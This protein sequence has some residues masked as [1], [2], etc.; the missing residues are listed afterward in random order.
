[1]SRVQYFP[2]P[3]SLWEG[4]STTT[5]TV[6]ERNAQMTMINSIDAMPCP[7][8]IP[9]D[10]VLGNMKMS[11]QTNFKNG[12]NEQH[13]S[14]MLL[15]DDEL[16][17]SEKLKQHIFTQ[18]SLRTAWPSKCSPPTSLSVMNSEETAI[19][20]E[21]LCG[22]K[23]WGEGKGYAAMFKSNGICGYMLPCLSIVALKEELGIEMFGHRLEIVAAIEQNELTLMN[24]I[25]VSLNPNMSFRLG[26]SQVNSSDLNQNK[27]KKHRK[28]HKKD[29]N[30]YKK[31]EQFSNCASKTTEIPSDTMRIAEG[32]GRRLE[33]NGARHKSGSVRMFNNSVI[34]MRGGGVFRVER[35]VEAPK[36]PWIPFL[37]LPPC[38]KE[39]VDMGVVEVQFGPWVNE[40]SKTKPQSFE[41][42]TQPACGKPVTCLDILGMLVDEKATPS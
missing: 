23:G 31:R 24:P 17:C 25:I 11:R 35:V 5:T 18:E 22:F 40:R 20:L 34:E 6:R 8:F 19:W 3:Y 36:Y 32:Y 15:V 39:F 10:F 7:Q 1:M 37:Q 13:G 41:N 2:V 33:R 42:S 12:N 29:K 27:K 4:V 26:T 14:S 9:E 28:K 21:M 16:D 30:K 38:K